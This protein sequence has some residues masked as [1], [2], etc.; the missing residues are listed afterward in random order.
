MVRR[1]DGGRG[2]ASHAA[3][4][5][6]ADEDPLIHTSG[7]SRPAKAASR[8]YGEVQK[9][10]IAT[11][12]ADARNPRRFA[13]SRLLHLEHPTTRLPP[14]K[15]SATASSAPSACASSPAKGIEYGLEVELGSLPLSYHKAIEDS[16]VPGAGAGPVRLAGDRRAGDADTQ[17][18]LV[19]RSRWP[20][21]SATS[22]RYVLLRALAAAGTR[23]FE[24]CHHFEARHPAARR[25]AR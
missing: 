6:M 25:S 1:G 14:W 18:L 21:T 13:P 20:A 17:R 8:L 16:V 9:E 19:T 7:D 4:L 22:P 3:L 11:T 12:L 15:S 10:V 23:V 2:I 24:P 5:R